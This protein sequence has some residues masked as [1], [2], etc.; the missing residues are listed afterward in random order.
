MYLK[1]NATL[2]GLIFVFFF[3]L[4][5]I[6]SF[7]YMPYANYQIY[8]FVIIVFTIIIAV[9]LPLFKKRYK[10]PLL[11]LFICVLGSFITYFNGNSIELCISKALYA[12]IG[13]IGFV[14]ISEKRINLRLFNFLIITLYLF[15]FFSYFRL[16][17]FT[18]KLIDGNLYGMSSSNTIAISLNIVLMIYYLLNK[19][20][21]EKNKRIIVFFALINLILIVIQGSRA[22][23]IVAFIL[24]IL[25]VSDLLNFKSRKR[26]MF[27]ILTSVLISVIIINMNLDKL[28][29]IVEIQR[30]QGLRSLQEDIRGT[31]QRSFF[32]KMDFSNFLLGYPSNTEFT[33]EITRTFN[34]F[35]DF[36]SKYGFFPFLFLLIL[37]FNRVIRFKAFNVS[38]IYFI[39]FFVYSLVESLWGGNSW[40][41]LI[42]LLLFYSYRKNE[43][44]LSKNK[45]IN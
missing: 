23:I 44:Y 36:W 43:N 45:E 41:I 20:Y 29:E 9:T 27:F 12:F 34:A 39:P 31:A 38:L 10:L 2:S 33:F 1:N 22:G 6:I 30:M 19:D 7:V 25:T 32:M 35:F 16:D 21:N 28:G 37:L 42:Y 14:Y 3:V 26:Y 5:Q 8:R 17:N 4:Q 24:L 40:D 18:R 15:F 13:Y 11:F